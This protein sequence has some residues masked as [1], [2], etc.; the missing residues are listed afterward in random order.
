MQH[1]KWFIG[2]VL[3]AVTLAWAGTAVAGPTPAQKCAA[4][5]LKAVSKK[6]SAKLKCTQTSITKGVPVDATC[7]TKAETKFS[8][9]VAKAESK[10][11]CP[12]TGDAA[13]LE[14]LADREVTSITAFTPVTRSRCCQDAFGLCWYEADP[15]T[16]CTGFI[17]GDPNSVCSP[18]T[19]TCVA[20]PAPPGL[21]CNNPSAYAPAA[22]SICF[23]GPENNSPP[24]LC[25]TQG[26]IADPNSLC[27]P[28][29]G[30]SVQF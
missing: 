2:C 8:T 20:Q 15:N 13:T 19:G 1:R 4:S 22:N 3:A 11:G 28:N 18:T 12:L 7:L 26:G 17:V 6:V 5:K 23:G 27:P 25:Q 24:G 29:G 9:A 30:N 10:G 21:S 14:A 16:T